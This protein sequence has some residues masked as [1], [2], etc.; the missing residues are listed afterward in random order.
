M[1]L[2]DAAQSLRRSSTQAAASAGERVQPPGQGQRATKA[3][4]K[5]W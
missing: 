5:S 3:Y 4:L 2:L 1:G